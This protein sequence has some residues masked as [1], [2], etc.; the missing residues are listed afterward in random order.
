MDTAIEA[1]TELA[2][3][4]AFERAELVSPPPRG[5]RAGSIPR[6]SSR[7]SS[8]SPASAR[9]RA[10]RRR[11]VGPTSSGSTRCGSPGGRNRPPDPLGNRRRQADLFGCR[12]VLR[13]VPAFGG[14]DPRR[15]VGG[16]SR[17][18]ATGS[19]AVTLGNGWRDLSARSRPTVFPAGSGRRIGDGRSP[20]HCIAERSW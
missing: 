11:P 13:Y 2:A 6:R 8:P 14:T 1:A 12:T 19:D 18:P 5:R 3:D 16:C 4:R 9:P 10:N 15:R 17:T 7:P 20:D